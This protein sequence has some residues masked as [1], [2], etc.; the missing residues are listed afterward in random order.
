MGR[1]KPLKGIKIKP[2]TSIKIGSNKIDSIDFSFESSNR[3]FLYLETKCHIPPGKYLYIF[4][5]R[6]SCIIFNLLILQPMLFIKS[7]HA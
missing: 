4:V 7:F 6:K 1:L 2:A 3:K 5:A